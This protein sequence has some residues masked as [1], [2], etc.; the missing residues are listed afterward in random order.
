MVDGV[1]YEV[2]D[3]LWRAGHFSDFSPPSRVIS[4]FPTLTGVAFTEAWDAD[5][6][7]GYED[8]YFD[9]E[10][11]RLR[12]GALDHFFGAEE[13]GFHGHVDIETG[14][15]TEALIYLDP[16]RLAHLELTEIGPALE[17]RLTRD[18]V[19]VAYIVSTDALAHREGR[20]AIVDFMHRL[21]VILADLRARSGDALEITL[22]SDHGNDLV[23]TRRAPL[24]DALEAAGLRRAGRLEGPR[25]VVIPRFGLVGSA[26]L[27]TDPANAPVLADALVGVPGVEL[28]LFRNARG[29]VQVRGAGTA[30][31]VEGDPDRERYAYRPLIGDPLGLAPAL[32]EMRRDGLLDSDGWAAADAWLRAS[33]ATPY[34]DSVRRL[35]RAF[36]GV[37]NGADVMVSLAAG[38]H[39]GSPM[40]DLIASVEGTHGSLRTASSLA[41]LMRTG[42]PAAETLRVEDVLP[43]IR[44][45]GSPRAGPAPRPAARRLPI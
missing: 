15:L 28:A 21:D 24:E 9:R 40:A 29:R 32:D 26:F 8:H 2:M 35:Y 34:I 31:V 25:D 41:F 5:P 22:F 14:G 17:A 11:N 16:G 44:P 3:S 18:S 6:R 30:A 7:P 1:P 13:D 33:E 42:P 12:G 43:I 23:P 4:P 39:Y 19:V 10:H 38:Y 27:Y 37:R 45:D 20:Q 36:S